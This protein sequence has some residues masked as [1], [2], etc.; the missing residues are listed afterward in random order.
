M[1]WIIWLDG[2]DVISPENQNRILELKRSAL[3]DELE[4]IYLRYV[5]PPFEQWRE[6]MARR[7][8]FGAGRLQWKGA[9]HEFIDGIDAGRAKYFDAISIVH[10]TPPDRMRGRRIAI[11]Q[12]SESITRRASL[13]IAASTFTPSNA[14]TACSEKRAT[15]PR[16]LHLTGQDLRISI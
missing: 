3:D 9:V 14:F 5:Y 15:D 10:D 16:P 13:T 4:A 11:S 2:D 7:E 8:P 12:S 6:R 1:D